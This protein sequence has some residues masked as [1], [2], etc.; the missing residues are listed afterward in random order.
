MTHRTI[1]AAALSA[2]LVLPSCRSH[3]SATTGRRDTTTHYT[4]TTRTASDT[5]RHRLTV[6]TADTART[7]AD[8][9]LLVEF[10]DSGGTA[11]I[12]TAGRL[13]LRGIKTLHARSH[14]QATQSHATSR[15]EN[16]S[17]A[18]TARHGGT[19]ADIRQQDTSTKQTQN[20]PARPRTIALG[21]AL[22]AL[23]WLL[24]RPLLRKLRQKPGK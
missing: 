9:L 22:G 18:R 20:T 12:D 16:T 24:R 5:T 23:L 7:T 13:T 15:T 1:L 14:T 2:L 8:G 17:A 3:S 6:I 21:L 11:H 19:T 4:D 10:T